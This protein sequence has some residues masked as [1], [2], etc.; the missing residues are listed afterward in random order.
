MEFLPVLLALRDRPPRAGGDEDDVRRLGQ[1]LE[2]FRARL[3]WMAGGE[4]AD[5]DAIFNAACFSI[6]NGA[7]RFNG[8]SEAEARRYC[9]QTVNRRAVDAYRR[10][11]RQWMYKVSAQGVATEDE[12]RSE[13]YF[14]GSEL[15]TEAENR[16]DA[17]AQR[18]EERE[19]VRA[20]IR[21]LSA[22]DREL[23]ER[24]G[25][26]GERVRDLATR[27]GI[28]ENTLTQRWLRA[29]GRLRRILT[30]ADESV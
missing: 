14:D 15:P 5:E 3:R 8:S 19:R 30:S 24:I 9:W 12:E 25:I 22:A 20:A 7:R 4:L 16:P 2:D 11:G 10:A 17:V 13:A 26:R 29:C 6:S 1:V 27:L 28:R 21:R 23:V 18:E